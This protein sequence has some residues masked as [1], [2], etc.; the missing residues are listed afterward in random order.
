MVNDRDLLVPVRQHHVGPSL[1]VLVN[2]SVDRLVVF[3][4]EPALSA[5][6]RWSASVPA[7]GMVLRA[8]VDRYRDQSDLRSSAPDLCSLVG[9]LVLQVSPEAVVPEELGDRV[10][11]FRELTTSLRA[12]VVLVNA[13]E[14]AH[15]VA[16]YLGG[17]SGMNVVVARS[18]L[19]E[20]K[21]DGARF[22]EV[23]P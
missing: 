2:G 3:C 15:A 23:L 6:E 21:L 20:L 9:D 4:G 14:P 13:T 22:F 10:R 18:F 19:R 11:L 7:F 1:N 8:D 17:R 12:L 16:T 5:V